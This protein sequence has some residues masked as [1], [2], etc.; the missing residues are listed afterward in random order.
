VKQTQ[1][2]WAICCADGVKASVA[3]AGFPLSTCRV[4]ALRICTANPAYQLKN[5]NLSQSA[6]Q[7]KSAKPTEEHVVN[8]QVVVITG[9]GG[10]GR[11]TGK[12]FR[13]GLVFKAHRLLYHST[14]GLRVIKKKRKKLTG[15]RDAPHSARPVARIST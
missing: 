7:L 5:V 11:P 2:V 3:E 1:K 4:N 12:R 9:Y 13:G 6:Y 14:L 15:M 8:K 10:R